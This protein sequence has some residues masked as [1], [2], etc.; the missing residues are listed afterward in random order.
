MLPENAM[1]A[2]AEEAARELA[3]SDIRSMTGSDLERVGYEMSE[4]LMGAVRSNDIIEL[5]RVSIRMFTMD[6][7]LYRDVNCCLREYDDGE[8]YF[9]KRPPTSKCDLRPGWA[10]MDDLGRWFARQRT[11]ALDGYESLAFYFILLEQALLRWP[12]R[13]GEVDVYRGVFLDDGEIDTY[14]ERVGKAV[15]LE[16]LPRRRGLDT[17][18]SVLET[19]SS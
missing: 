7:T 15:F 16:D 4:M 12:Q 13:L 2:I 9:C 18:P 10:E 6:T 11:M 5:Y 19:Y 1:F 17:L 8:G 14:R 3:E